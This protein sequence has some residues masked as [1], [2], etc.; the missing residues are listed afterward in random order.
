[1]TRNN[2]QNIISGIAIFFSS[3]SVALALPMLGDCFMNL[4]DFRQNLFAYENA[5]EDTNIT[6]DDQGR[7]LWMVDKTPGINYDR[8]LL[9]RMGDKVC[10]RAQLSA[11][12]VDL[13]KNA[14]G[15]VIDVSIPPIGL[16]AGKSGRYELKPNGAY[17]VLTKCWRS[18][19]GKKN[20]TFS[21]SAWSD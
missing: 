4:N 7:W 14:G 9:E 12:S 18:S 21:C 3:H 16:T 5:E 10:Y 19:A 13:H 20:K 2:F 11:N 1:M 17:F 6:D 8:S 15:W